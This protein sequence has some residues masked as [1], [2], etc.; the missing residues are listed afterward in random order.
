MRQ[1]FDVMIARR[2]G[3]EI[4]QDGRHPDGRPFRWIF[5][6]ITERSFRWR[7]EVSADGGRS[8]T[9]VVE[10]RGRRTASESAAA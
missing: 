2:H 9:A 4:L 6:E 8:W 3:N 1:A 7:A 10:F 5:S